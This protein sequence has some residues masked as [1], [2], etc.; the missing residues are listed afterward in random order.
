ML[1]SSIWS[2]DSDTCKVWITLLAMQD[3]EG[4]VFG[5][6]SGLARIAALPV[7]SILVA[8]K[9]FEEPDKYS[10][11]LGR[12]PEREGRR[13]KAVPGGWLIFNGAFYRGLA[14]AEERRASDA[15]RQRTSRQK[16]KRGLS[17]S[18][19]VGHGRSQQIQ[20]A[21]SE[22]ESDT[23]K[24]PEKRREDPSGEAPESGSNGHARKLTPQQQKVEFAELLLKDYRIVPPP[25]STI[26]KWLTYV[27]GGELLEI[28][29]E[30]KG[31]NKL[32]GMEPKA[33]TSYLF[34]CIKRFDSERTPAQRR[35]LLEAEGQ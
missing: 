5:S 33:V 16:R 13:I 27:D 28:L 32:E 9:K 2:E 14:D 23:E 26:A 11:D 24:K 15:E 19:T 1:N 31:G 21:E 25:P 10:A 7:E 12:E 6:P 8:L 4:Y 20:H 29:D 3:R 34:G 18:V 17:R 35:A 22:S 30:L